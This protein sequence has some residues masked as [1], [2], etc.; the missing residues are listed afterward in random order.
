MYRISKKFSFCASHC[1]AKL[2]EGHPCSRVHGHNYTV[3]LV[4]GSPVLNE[5]GFVLDYRE[6]TPFKTFIDDTLD[7]RHLNEVLTFHPT[8]ENIAQFL[9]M[10][11]HELFGGHVL[12]V[13]VSETEKTMAEFSIE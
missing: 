4:L 8:A 2:P 12:A 10:K 7:H 5:Y 3:E 6:M 13:R 1:L 9:F 11:A